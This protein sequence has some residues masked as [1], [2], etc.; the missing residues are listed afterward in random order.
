MKPTSSSKIQIREKKNF[1][2]LSLL[3][4]GVTSPAQRAQMPGVQHITKLRSQHNV[5]EFEQC[6]L[7]F[8]TDSRSQLLEVIAIPFVVTERTAIVDEHQEPIARVVDHRRWSS[9]SIVGQRVEHHH[10]IL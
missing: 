4:Q 9:G 10:C 7:P 8:V 1:T 2:A 3:N 5:I 6:D